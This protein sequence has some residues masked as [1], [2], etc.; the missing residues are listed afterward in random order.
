MSML[1]RGKVENEKSV[2]P[3]QI[4]EE[5]NTIWK[6]ANEIWKRE[7]VQL[8][9]S[10]RLDQIYNQFWESHRDLF[11]SYPTVMRHMLQ[12]K[13]YHKEAFRKYLKRLS[14]VP[15]TNDEQRMNSYADYAV[16]LYKTLND[17]K[18]GG[19]GWTQSMANELRDDYL[20]RAQS[21]H[22]EFKRKYERHHRDV[23]ADEKRLDMERR[24][25]LLLNIQQ[26]AKTLG[27]ES[28]ALDTLDTEQLKKV[29]DSLVSLDI[30]SVHDDTENIV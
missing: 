15:W 18:H 6:A 11:S 20:K 29:S 2:T 3:E 30:N 17:R 1:A 24:S 14:V 16:L 26:I 25:E 4:L 19:G 12:E 7:N 27:L 13:Q 23:E 21:E 10:K 22:E 5:T 28:A 9:D 8:E